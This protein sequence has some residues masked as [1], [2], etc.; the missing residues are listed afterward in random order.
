[1]A[2]LKD[3]EPYA[4]WLGYNAAYNREKKDNPYDY[5][6]AEYQQY[7]DGFTS[8]TGAKGFKSTK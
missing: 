1:M 6:A 3:E 5:D 8:G 4:F 7:E 2:G